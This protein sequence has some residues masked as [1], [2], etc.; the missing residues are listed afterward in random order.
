MMQGGFF[1]ELFPGFGVNH[2]VILPEFRCRKPLSLGPPPLGSRCIYLY[3]SCKSSA[4]AVFSHNL[5]YRYVV[6]GYTVTIH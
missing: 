6:M 3:L 1:V 5:V 2:I 4:L